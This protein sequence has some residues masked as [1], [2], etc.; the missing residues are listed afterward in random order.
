VA[1][2][3]LRTRLS[4]RA[5]KSGLFL[6]DDLTARLLAYYELLSRWNQKINLTAL[7]DP[8]AAID[9]LLL[10]PLAAVRLFPEGAYRFMDIGSGG[11]SPALPMKMARP[12]WQLTMVE[13]KARKSAFLREAVRVL[14]LEGTTVETARYEELLARPDLHEAFRIVSMRAVRVETRVLHSLQAFLVPG[15]ELFLFR[16]PSGPEAPGAIVPPL[17]WLG[18]T[19][20]LESLQSRLTSLRKR[21]VGRVPR[22]TAGNVV[23]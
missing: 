8:D 2:R 11:G 16:G 10:E 9:R 12:D 4:R 21:R 19:P 6:S 3:D 1:P 14:Q 17:E 7:D 15:G 13:A 18:T 22:G 20:L 5:G 23:R